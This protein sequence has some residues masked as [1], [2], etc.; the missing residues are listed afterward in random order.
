MPFSSRT[1]LS[2]AVTLPLLALS[3]AGCAAGVPR[4]AAAPG[5]QVGIHFTCNLPDGGVAASTRPSGLGSRTLSP[6]YK[7]RNNDEPL[8]MTAGSAAIDP[9]DPLGRGFEQEVIL[10]LQELLV[11]ARQGDRMTVGIAAEPVAGPLEERQLKISRIRK[12]PKQLKLSPA[13][14]QRRT[15]KAPAPG[16]AY[17]LEPLLAG[18]VA[19]VTAEEV[20]LTFS[21]SPDSGVSLGF[22]PG[23][24]REREE[25][26]EIEIQAVP[27][28]L[29][30]SGGMVGRIK[31]VDSEFIHVDYSHPFGGEL[32][33]CEVTVES[34]QPKAA[35][36]GAPAPG[37]APAAV[38]E[39]GSGEL[40]QGE[41]ARGS[42]ESAL[43]A[44]GAAAQ[45]GDLV[46]VHYTAALEDGAI[47]STTRESAA[48][49]P[50]LKRVPW[51]QEPSRYA[52]EEIV[53]G[54][55]E[56]LPG[57]G[58]AVIGMKSGEK[59]QLKLAPEQAFGLPDPQ[60]LVSLP[61]VRELPRIV[62]LPADEYLKQFATLPVLNKE[63]ELV[64]YFKGKVTEVTEHDVQVEFLAKDGDRFQDSYGTVAIG[65]QGDRITTTLTPVL[66]AQFPVLDGEG[67]ISA[68]D[69][70]TFTVDGNHPLAGKT[71]LLDLE[72]A[73]VIQASA[74]G[75][76]IDWTED[77][78]LG[79]AR[80]RQEGK[81]VLL[82][83]YAD[84]CSWSKKTFAEIIP[85]PRIRQLKE[86]FVWVKLD[87]DKKQEYQKQFGQEG[88]PMTLVLDGEGK[89]LKK[90]AGCRDARALKE[91]V[92]GL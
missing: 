69:G 45:S 10:R 89:V 28:T 88:F 17:L 4:Q 14:Y 77:L 71:V 25:H 70:A 57:V 27:G 19:Q 40:E 37:A 66:G 83:L 35:E 29:V 86:K 73:S 21:A 59:K 32:L 92:L 44:P 76:P 58:Q 6:L 1:L 11:G 5:D 8:L 34:V 43:P 22:G 91:L 61:C 74:A 16:D 52:A 64:P 31:E 41:A 62:R 90:I 3:L 9:V 36:Q 47:F 13:E 38:S 87:S 54:R 7:K 26:F 79:L 72:V 20:L 30:R 18:K 42:K 51:F 82:V 12:R 81:P 67:I 80:A 48:K 23:T 50:A 2:G 85:D 33:S 68:T 65:V 75:P 24:V 39:G 46:T 84:W 78:E 15:G 49:D 63:I 53:A 60:K 55:Q 56:L